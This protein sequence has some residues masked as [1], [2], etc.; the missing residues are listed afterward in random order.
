MGKVT[1]PMPMFVRCVWFASWIL[2]FHSTL[3]TRKTVHNDPDMVRRF[4]GII[5]SDKFR[6][7][8]MNVVDSSSGRL[9]SDSE[10]M[11]RLFSGVISEAHSQT[12]DAEN[13][14]QS[15]MK[16]HATTIQKSLATGPDIMKQK[17]GALLNLMSDADAVR[18]SSEISVNSRKMVEDLS[19]G[20]DMNKDMI[21]GLGGKSS[22]GAFALQSSVQ[23][24]NDVPALQAFNEKG[25]ISA[26]VKALAGVPHMPHIN[27]KD[28]YQMGID[29]LPKHDPDERIKMRLHNKVLSLANTDSSTT[30]GDNP[31]GQEPNDETSLNSADEI[32]FGARHASMTLGSLQGMSAFGKVPGIQM[33][34]EFTND[35]L[36]TDVHVHEKAMRALVGKQH[37]ELLRMQREKNVQLPTQ[38]LLD[39]FRRRLV[40]S[41]E[42]VMDDLYDRMHHK[43]NKWQDQGVE[44]LRSM[45]AKGKESMSNGHKHWKNLVFQHKLRKAQQLARRQEL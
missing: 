27:F 29:S 44:H 42:D 15:H 37:T 4:E 7:Q 17:S 18:S 13:S 11:F 36:S 3:A 30:N 24:G 22:D 39:S 33:P 10:D 8:L 21:T 14:L 1:K 25:H 40:D 35:E 38:S 34:G 5:N 19:E 31:N 26:N 43:V 28:A 41:K 45:T 12:V 20:N 23:A 6:S 2:C 16:D 32:P 9:P